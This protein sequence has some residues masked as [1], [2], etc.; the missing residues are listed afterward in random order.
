MRYKLSADIDGW[1]LLPGPTLTAERDGLRFELHADAKGL[2]TTAAVSVQV[3]PEKLEAFRNTLTK[4]SSGGRNAPHLRV[5]GDKE[6][7]DRLIVGLQE[8]ESTLTDIQGGRLI[9]EIAWHEAKDEFIPESPGDQALL[10][11]N[12]IKISQPHRETPV[13]LH[14]KAFESIV[15]KAPRYEPLF[16]HRSIWREATNA[17]N[18]GKHLY[19]ILGFWFLVE[20]LY[21]DGHTGKKQVLKAFKTN[22]RFKRVLTAAVAGFQKADKNYEAVQALFGDRG[23]SFTA[24]GAADF[25]FDMR[26]HLLHF[27]S[28]DRGKISPLN[29]R[30]FRPLSLFFMHV[31]NVALLYEIVALNRIADGLDPDVYD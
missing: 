4:P 10:A 6:L 8:L 15:N 5:G 19:A 25:I 13:R 11:I 23:H 14:Q 26:G 12:A 27:S 16:V 29:Q 21:A 30:D 20:D 2:A 18:D 28:R 17:F 9:R 24:E 3:P 7:R 31:A 22:P 1:L